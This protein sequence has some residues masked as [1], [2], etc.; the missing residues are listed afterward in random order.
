MNAPESLSHPQL[1]GLLT[2]VRDREVLYA[3]HPGNAGD[4]LIATATYQLLD[5]LLPAYQVTE[6]LGGMQAEASGKVVLLGG[7]GNLI[8]QSKGQSVRKRL[9]IANEQ[10]DK[11]ILLPHTITG[12]VDLLQ[13]LGPHVHIFCRETP[14]YWHTEKHVQGARVYL[15]HDLAFSLDLNNIDSAGKRG[16]TNETNPERQTAL[17]TTRS[18]FKRIPIVVKSR[19]GTCGTISCFR[20]DK[21]KLGDLPERNYDLSALCKRSSLQPSGARRAVNSMLGIL[22]RFQSVRTNRLHIG[23]AG[24]MLGKD[25]QLFPNNYFKNQAV[26]EWS[27]HRYDNVEWCPMPGQAGWGTQGGT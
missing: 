26:Y 1:R 15:E 8:T 27:L 3:P 2:E 23:I 19:L 21:E 7:G 25:V 14:S 13:L 11:V 12:N 9:E 24:A 16:H 5:N 6:T 22:M 17:E 4:A 18:V 10:A 20:T